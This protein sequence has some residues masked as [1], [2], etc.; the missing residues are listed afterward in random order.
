[1]KHELVSYHQFKV[2]LLNNL[3]QDEEEVDMEFRNLKEFHRCK[4]LEDVNE[5]AFDR[6]VDNMAK[7]LFHPDDHL[8][9]CQ[10]HQNHHHL[11]GA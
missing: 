4:A 9:D 7:V 10:I 1:M 5:N 6:I 8:L 2:V 11:P 3:S